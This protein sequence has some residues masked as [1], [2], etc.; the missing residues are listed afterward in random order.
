MI[1]S[2]GYEFTLSFQVFLKDL[3]LEFSCNETDSVFHN[4]APSTFTVLLPKLDL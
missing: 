4:V 1:Y 2:T 3:R